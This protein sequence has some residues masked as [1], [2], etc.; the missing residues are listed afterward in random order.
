MDAILEKLVNPV[1]PEIQGKLVIYAILVRS[2]NRANFA[3]LVKEELFARMKTDK[4][5]KVALLATNIDLLGSIPNYS[6]NTHLMPCLV[7]PFLSISTFPENLHNLLAM[8]VCFTA[9]LLLS[10][11]LF[12][13]LAYLIFFCNFSMFC[14]AFWLE[15][16]YICKC[17][18]SSIHFYCH[19]LNNISLYSLPKGTLLLYFIWIND[20][21]I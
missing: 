1:K 17:S 8:F 6:R 16:K 15:T 12:Q 18:P 5:E 19:I 14:M 7:L 4:K 10:L 11:A 13:S 9:Y 3:N 21:L 2:V 20:Q